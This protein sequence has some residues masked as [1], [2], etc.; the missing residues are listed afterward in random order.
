MFSLNK[1]ASSI[2]L[3][4]LVLVVAFSVCEV[5]SADQGEVSPVRFNTAFIYGAS[6]PVNLEE[7]LNGSKVVEGVYRVDL[8]VN[9]RLVGRQDIRFAKNPAS[10]LV[11]AC[12]TKE[13]L[14]TLSVDITKLQNAGLLED[15]QSD[16]C[17]DLAALIEKSSVD[18]D[19]SQ[20]Q[21][22]IS[23]PQAAMQRSSRGYVNPELWDNGVSAM[24]VDYQFNGRS[25]SA[26][27]RST[28][29]YHLGLRNGLNIGAWR[30]R[31]E[32]ALSSGAH[33]ERRYRNNR[34]YVQ[35]DL[36][37]LKSQLTFGETYTKPQVFDSVRIRG[38][39]LA[40]DDAMLPDSQR[41]YAP[42]IRGD[43][44][45]NATVE[46]RQNGYLLY[47]TNVSPGP[48]AITDIYPSGSNGD[49]EVT[50]IEADGR[51]RQFVQSFASLPQ[52]VRE[53]ML[54]FNVA[55]G[56]YDSHYDGGHK[57]DLATAG[58]AYGFTADTTV[59]GGLQATNRFEAVN[60]GLSRNTPLGAVSADIT[61]SGSDV[62]AKR[63]QGQSVRLLYAKTLTT[64]D[65]TLT[66]ASY[67]YSTEQY[68]TLSE[69]VA[70]LDWGKTTRPAGRARSRFDLT[71]N[72]NLRD[73][74]ASLYLNLS[75]QRY[76]NRGGK[77]EHVQAGYSSHWKTL[78]YNLSVA[79]DRHPSQFYRDESRFTVTLSMPL[80]SQPRAAR[81]I[82]N[83]TH[84]DKGEYNAQAGI[85]GNIMD[86][87]DSFYTVQAG[88]DS[89]GGNS[90]VATVSTTTQAARLNAGYSQGR[91]YKALN[92]GVSGAVVGHAGGINMAQPLAET[93]VLVEVPGV[94][95]ARLASYT[96]V[97]TG[98]NGYAVVPY[99]TP[100]RNNWISLDTRTM[101]TDV[102][103][104]DPTQQVVPR[105]GSITVAR[106]K[107]QSGRRVQFEL[108]D[109]A[110]RAMPFGAMVQD[111]EGRMLSVVDPLGMALVLVREGQ[112]QLQV[113]GAEETCQVA[114]TLPEPTPGRAYERIS[115][116]CK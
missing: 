89:I 26:N 85:S 88:H 80:G 4:S 23:V 30:L 73:L 53:G 20:L 44:D 9:R 98:S 38:I 104:T 35:R 114:F 5:T 78:N 116:V 60:L 108:T 103:I 97:S 51:Q 36:T 13:V 6:G 83:G 15:K 41:G 68:R 58:V 100:Y 54:R 34:S 46:V 95:Q 42:I 113:K 69:H 72:Q 107:T 67:R 8:V 106:F 96:G 52:M 65:T 64:T 25:G 1:I 16:A 12:L 27:G 37:A 11:E 45:T 111:S 14:E 91:G 93:I 2:S 40:S 92:V 102:E 43:A 10:G 61:H 57:P 110:G 112:E 90:G 81:A 99:A 31:N 75:E 55:A 48:F 19:A 63:Q 49:L 39:E 33:Q 56:R 74:N 32:S 86:R 71:V 115:A 7:F 29:N 109:A 18:Y 17:V 22:N 76:W 79:H 21:L 66:L 84:T 94:E 24:F 28:D 70:D 59:F 101:D 3:K 105:R 50:I 47:S 77:T 62:G 82:F 87:D